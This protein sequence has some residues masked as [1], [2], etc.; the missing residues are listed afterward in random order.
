[1]V[2]AELGVRNNGPATIAQW[3]EEPG[4]D[5]ASV[6]TVTVPP[7]TTAVGVP[8]QCRAEGD[9]RSGE[10]GARRYSCFQ[11]IDDYYFDAKQFTPFVFELRIDKP[12][13]LAPGS[14]KVSAPAH[15]SND[16]NNTAAIMVTVGGKPGGGSGGSGSSS[17][18]TGSTGGSGS[19]GGS[20]SAGGSGATASGGTTRGSLAG[21]GAGAL[22]RYAAAAGAALAAGAAM[23]ALVRRR[24]R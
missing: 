17:A 8:S 15:D 14:V 23:F 10:P 16:G 2:Q 5:P 4:D 11:D 12:G 6:T 1:M 19:G 3:G 22:P 21:A 20:G 13:D 9:L 24:V 18:G 7:G